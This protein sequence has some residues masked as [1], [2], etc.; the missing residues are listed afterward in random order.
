MRAVAIAASLVVN[1]AV[2]RL[3]DDDTGVRFLVPEDTRR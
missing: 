3:R 2:S 1:D